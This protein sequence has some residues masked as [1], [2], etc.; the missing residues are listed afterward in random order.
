MAH[1]AKNFAI[2]TRRINPRLDVLT[3]QSP[4]RRW[5]CYRL[6]IGRQQFLLHP[7][8]HKDVY[9]SYADFFADVDIHLIT[10]KGD[11]KKPCVEF[12]KRT[13]VSLYAHEQEDL[14][15]D[16]PVTTFS[17]PHVVAQGLQAL[18]FPGHTPGYTAYRWSYRG[19][20]Y[21][22][23]GHLIWPSRHGWFAAA[24][25]TDFR[26]SVKSIQALADLDCDFLLPEGCIVRTDAP[27]HVP[28]PFGDA[29]RRA[30]VDSAGRYLQ[31]KADAVLKKIR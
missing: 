27:R 18:H 29:E 28:L 1:W 4:T 5:H 21:L 15:A 10:H 11:V 3:A 12:A 25:A 22:F 26:G 7:P 8:D 14:P 13:G 9:T 23:G 24:S 30:A 16:A 20:N 2:E 31:Q 17:E 6:S 19:K